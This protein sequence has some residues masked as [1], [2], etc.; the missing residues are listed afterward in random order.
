MVKTNGCSTFTL[1]LLSVT[2]YVALLTR[3]VMC[4]E[5]SQYYNDVNI[6][7]WT[8]GSLLTKSAAQTACQQR[9]SFLPRITNSDIQSKLAEFRSAAG[10]LLGSNGFWIGVYVTGI[11]NFHWIDSSQ[12]AG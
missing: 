8:N 5:F 12:L 3:Q 6:C 4:E 7:L 11:D 10:D 9:N 1:K 2:G